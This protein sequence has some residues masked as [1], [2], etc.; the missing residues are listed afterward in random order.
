MQKNEPFPP[1]PSFP[2]VRSL[3]QAE[4]ECTARL[5]PFPGY[6]ST[7]V[8]PPSPEPRSRRGSVVS[9]YDN[10][11]ASAAITSSSAPAAAARFATAPRNFGRRKGQRE[12]DDGEGTASL[13]LRPR[14]TTSTAAASPRPHSGGLSASDKRISSLSVVSG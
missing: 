4:P 13:R 3:L 7:G 10:E 6:L 14:M 9:V 1:F 5:F 2:Y 11:P 12:D 8:L